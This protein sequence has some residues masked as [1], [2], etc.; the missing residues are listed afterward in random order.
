ML[1]RQS[2]LKPSLHRKFAFE[3][4]GT[5]W[6]IEIGG[7]IAATQ[8]LNSVKVRI[9]AFD[10]NYSRF[11]SD[12]LVTKMSLKAGEYILPDDAKPMLDL[13]RELYIITSGFMTPLIG[14]TLSDAGYDSSYSLKP[15]TLKK[16]PAWDECMIYDFPKLTIKQPVLLDFGAAGKGYLVD[17]IGGLLRAN[18]CREFVI[19]AG[20][21][22]LHYGSAKIDVALEHPLNFDEAVGIATIKNQALC[23]SAGNRRAWAGYN[24]IINP[25]SLESPRHLQAVWACTE[26][27]ML[28]DALTTA[29]YFCSPVE[30]SKRYTFSYGIIGSDMSLKY[31]DNF[32]AKF[33]DAEG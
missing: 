12:S 18:G 8:V 17:I 6:E 11:R 30:L 14:Q 28:A 24:H 23:G 3:A 15:G 16:P 31:S 27:T 33:F 9:E 19:N 25:D 2:K 7:N 5:Q 29:L 13:Y 1:S 20:G 22:I 10:K 21:D 4:I 32:P 26:T